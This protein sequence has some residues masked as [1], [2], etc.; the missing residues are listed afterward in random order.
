MTPPS[1]PP[2]IAPV[3]ED[4]PLGLGDALDGTEGLGSVP[5]VKE[6]DVEVAL[7]AALETEEEVVVATIQ[8]ETVQ[9]QFSPE[10]ETLSTKEYGKFTLLCPAEITL[11]SIAPSG[12]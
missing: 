3:S 9:L 2:A 10:L 8:Q 6:S 7:E 12:A 1:T 5:L 11:S 4:E